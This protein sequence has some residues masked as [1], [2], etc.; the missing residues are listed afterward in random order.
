MKKLFLFFCLGVLSTFAADERT[1]IL[2]LPT[3]SSL[4][5]SNSYVPVSD[6][7]TFAT[8]KVKVNDLLANKSDTNHTH[9]AADIPSV[10]P[11][12]NVSDAAYNAT[13]W[14]GDTN[15]PTKNAI[16]DEVEVLSTA[17]ANASAVYANGS[18]ISAPNLTNSATA[19]IAVSA[20]T[21]VTVNP[22]NISNAQIAASAGI[23]FSKLS[24]VAP[25]TSGT[26]LLKGNGS[27]GF[28]PAVSSTDYAPATSGSAILKGN[29]SGGFSSAAAGTDYANTGQK[30]NYFAATTSAE[31]AGVLSDESGTG[32]AA[33]TVQSKMRGTLSDPIALGS[34]TSFAI[35]PAYSVYTATALGNVTLSLATNSVTA[36]VAFKSPIAIFLYDGT[37]SRTITLSSSG[38]GGS[39]FSGGEQSFGFATNSP[40]AGTN[41]V[42]IDW[43]GAVF[44]FAKNTDL[45]AA[46]QVQYMGGVNST[47]LT[48]ISTNTVTNKTFDAAATGNVLKQIR[49]LK[50]QF[51][52]VIDGTGCTYVNTNDVTANTFMVP[53]FS[54]TGATNA[55]YCRFAFR[56]PKDIDTSVDLTASLTVRLTGADTSAHTY[57]VGLSSVANS[58]AAT[59]SAGNWVAL[60]LGSDASGASDDIE[61][62]NDTTLTAWK[63]NLTAN[64]W[65]GVELR[66]DGANDASTVASDLMELEIFYTST[67]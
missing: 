28:N 50:L 16:R 41:V 22:T 55:N 67:Q 54:G 21:N 14:N 63:S 8:S 3:I 19:T 45:I 4:N 13:S 53:R 33:Y 26:S 11:W 47:V 5:R 27:G 24:G 15:I 59:F 25:A 35:D 40:T 31:L 61:S 39:A 12:A 17:I 48:D 36:G 58:S 51:P 38:T 10:V 37:G 29:G 6:R 60:S 23:V 30:L 44:H 42:L 32:L 49:S 20:T 2:N 1:S 65:F 7:N 46:R 66:R 43:D 18:L 57:H 52:R 62:V 56:V 34:G 9:V 64:Q